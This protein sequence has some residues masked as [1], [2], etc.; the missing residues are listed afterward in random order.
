MKKITAL[1]LVV[2]TVFGLCAC[3]SESMKDAKDNT[4]YREDVVDFN[5]YIPESWILDC[6]SFVVSAHAGEQDNSTVMM[7][8][9]DLPGGT[10]TVSSIFED[11]RENMAQLYT[12]KDDSPKTETKVAGEDAE[13][14]YYTLTDKVTGKALRYLQCLFIRDFVLYTFTYYATPENYEKHLTEVQ[15]MLD[16]IDFGKSNPPKGMK[17]AMSA[18]T[19][20]VDS[21]DFSIQIPEDWTVDTSTG[22]FTAIAASGDQSNLSVMRAEVEADVSAISYYKQHEPS[23]KNGLAEFVC[24][25]L[26]E[27][28][29]IKDSKGKSYNAVCVTYTATVSDMEYRFK[30]LFCKKDTTMYIVTFSAPDA[31]YETHKDAFEKSIL[32]FTMVAK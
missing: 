1:L 29:I 17:A 7:T 23:L 12:L 16:N 8:Q 4:V 13:I 24:E 27:D 14:Y 31:L 5:L 9:T 32:S 26:D 15:T 25:A 18:G 22:V 21:S 28:L 11:T 30:Q 3:T 6:T 10:Y 2:I 20:F 19:R